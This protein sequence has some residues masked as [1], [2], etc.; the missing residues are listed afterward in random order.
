MLIRINYDLPLYE[1]APSNFL[2]GGQLNYYLICS[3]TVS[4]NSTSTLCFTTICGTVHRGD[5][6]GKK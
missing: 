4:L 2:E 6:R 3:N 5:L 1:N